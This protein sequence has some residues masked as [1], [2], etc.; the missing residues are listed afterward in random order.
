MARRAA[1]ALV[2]LVAFGGGT[3]TAGAPRIDRPAKP[4]WCPDR[5]GAGSYDARRILGRKLS[6]ARILARRERCTVRVVIR[7][8]ES[9]AVTKDYNRR[10]INVEVR[11]WIV[12]GLEDVG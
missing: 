3:A 4:V 2:V 10:R 5:G 12:V 9:L 1:T 7:D 8:G 11:R 6:S